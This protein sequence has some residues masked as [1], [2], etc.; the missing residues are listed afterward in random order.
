[1][2]PRLQFGL[3]ANQKNP[4][5]ATPVQIKTLS[6]F[7]MRGIH[8]LSTG[9]I[10]LAFGAINMSLTAKGSRHRVKPPSSFPQGAKA[11]AKRT[12]V[13]TTIREDDPVPRRRR[14]KKSSNVV[15]IIIVVLLV[16]FVWSRTQHSTGPRP[17][18]VTTSR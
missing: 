2:Q 5:V 14:N 3:L 10:C 4:T 11:M 17:A 16:L 12:R 8:H 9:M 18:P 7:V 6:C 13:T 1:M 15:L